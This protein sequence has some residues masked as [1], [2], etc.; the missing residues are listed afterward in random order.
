MQGIA[1]Q[2]ATH[3][4]NISFFRFYMQAYAQG[5]TEKKIC[6]CSYNN[7]CTQFLLHGL[8]FL[9]YLNLS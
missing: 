9:K 1:K 5:V 6:I 8:S 4:A 3:I 7:P 2:I